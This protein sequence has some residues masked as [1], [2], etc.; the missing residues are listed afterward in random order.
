MK[1]RVYNGFMAIMTAVLCLTFV[2]QAGADYVDEVL[3]DNPLLWLRLEEYNMSNGQTAFS[4]GSAARDGTYIAKSPARKAVRVDGPW[5]LVV[6]E[7]R[8][9][10]DEHPIPHDHGVQLRPVLDFAAVG[11]L[12]TIPDIHP[13]PDDAVFPDIDVF[14][15]MRERPHLR[16]FPDLYIIID[17]ALWMK[18]N[19]GQFINP[20]S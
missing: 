17:K 1:K 5:V 8:T 15:D 11:D 9:R 2:S 7:D 3:A 10:P 20:A 16:S 6:A 18:R 19:P 12:R 4:S 14:A 13:F